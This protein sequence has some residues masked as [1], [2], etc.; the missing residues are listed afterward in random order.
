MVKH[1]RNVT[2]ISPIMHISCWEGRILF[3][4]A[5]YLSDNAVGI[6]QNKESEKNMFYMSLV[7][8]IPIFLRKEVLENY[9]KQELT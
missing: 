8:Y 4:L 9:N 6:H 3:V 2:C 7:Q 1:I 5:L